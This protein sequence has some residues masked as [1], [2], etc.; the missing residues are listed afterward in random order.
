VAWGQQWSSAR[1]TRGGR[2]CGFCDA[3]LVGRSIL[4]TGICG[5]FVGVLVEESPLL[6]CGAEGWFMGTGQAGA[7]RSWSTGMFGRAMP[8]Q[9]ERKWIAYVYLCLIG[10]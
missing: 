6:L 2:T 8:R 5:R 10:W 7:L 4:A 1:A 3:N 9:R